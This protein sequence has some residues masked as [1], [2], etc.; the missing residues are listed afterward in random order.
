MFSQ[1]RVSH[2]TW[3]IFPCNQFSWILNSTRNHTQLESSSKLYKEYMNFT[4]LRFSSP[5]ICEY[6]S[7]EVVSSSTKKRFD[8]KQLLDFN[9]YLLAFQQ[10]KNEEES[11]RNYGVMAHFLKPVKPVSQLPNLESHRFNLSQTNSGEQERFIIILELYPTIQEEYIRILTMHQIPHDKEDLIVWELSKT[12]CIHT[13]GNK[14]PTTK[15]SKLQRFGGITWFS[16]SPNMHQHSPEPT[17][18]TKTS[19]AIFG[20]ILGIICHQFPMALSKPS[21]QWFRPSLQHSRCS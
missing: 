15:P 5:S 17:G 12:G 21:L 20:V 2:Q 18:S 13:L 11:P 7:L 19:L 8:P 4:S 14:S 10:A 1:N 9:M 16:R 6:P 3:E